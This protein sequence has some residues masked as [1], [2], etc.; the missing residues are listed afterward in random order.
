MNKYAEI[1]TTS[2][3]GLFSVKDVIACYINAGN[4]IVIDYANG[5]QSKIDGS[6]ALVQADLD[7]VFGAIKQAQQENWKKVKVV[8]PSLSSA[9][10]SV[11]FTF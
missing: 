6:S 9:V 4:D 2:G 10:T 8:I 11:V 7:I 3:V 1:T 5:S